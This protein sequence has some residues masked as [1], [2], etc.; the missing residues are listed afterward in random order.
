MWKAAESVPLGRAVGP[1]NNNLGTGGS[2]VGFSTIEDAVVVTLNSMDTGAAAV[3][4]IP[5]QTPPQR[6][7]EVALLGR[8]QNGSVYIVVLSTNGLELW[9]QMDSQHG[10]ECPSYSRSSSSDSFTTSSNNAGGS[11]A[12]RLTA[13]IALH[14]LVDASPVRSPEL[15][16]AARVDAGDL[17]CSGG[18]SGTSYICVGTSSGEVAVCALGAQMGS[19]SSTARLKKRLRP[20]TTD[21][22]ENSD[23]P[24]AAPPL[25]AAAGF[26]P[27]SCLCAAGLSGTLLAVGDDDGTIR[28]RSSAGEFSRSIGVAGG[29]NLCDVAFPAPPGDVPCTCLAAKGDILLASFASGNIRWVCWWVDGWMGGGWIGRSSLLCSHSLTHL[30]PWHISAR[31]SVPLYLR[32]LQGDECR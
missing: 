9:R 24:A 31:P 27:I 6:V 30:A 20:P 21:A 15:R 25:A 19:S 5:F 32:V 16:G 8:E 12:P 11:G 17:D 4:S 1:S 29:A 26:A 13:L 28:V 7:F 14:V 18:G 2:I 10:G 22:F 23:A 3:K